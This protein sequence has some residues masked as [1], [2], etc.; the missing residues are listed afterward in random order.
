MNKG[1]AVTVRE[2]STGNT[3]LHAAAA[4][5]SGGAACIHFFLCQRPTPPPHAPNNRDLF[6]LHVAAS[7]GNAEAIEALLARGERPYLDRAA[8]SEGSPLVIAAKAGRGP[9]MRV[10]LEHG[11]DANARWERNRTAL[12]VAAT[13]GHLAAVAVLVLLKPETLAAVD[14]VGNTALH[15]AALSGH[16]AVIRAM[17]PSPRCNLG[18]QNAL[19]Q[20]A[21]HCAVDHGTAGPVGVIAGHMSVSDR[22]RR[23]S[24]GRTALEAAE[25]KPPHA[26]AA[27]V[28]AELRRVAGLPPLSRPDDSVTRLALG[29]DAAGR[30]PPAPAAASAGP[31]WRRRAATATATSG[32]GPRRGHDATAPEFEAVPPRPRPDGKKCVV[33]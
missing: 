19:G 21:L 17:L 29:A 9:A 4:A 27:A 1:A 18:A 22:N 15:L 10:L 12:H 31:P 30:Q 16:T 20:T 23:D 6:P 2:T 7:V 26:R 25:A 24:E 13:R 33:A 8:L 11:A 3:A 32:T 5:V 28:I 14:N